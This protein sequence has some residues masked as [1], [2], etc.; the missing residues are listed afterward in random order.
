MKK[1]KKII[2]YLVLLYSFSGIYA[3]G[4]Y[5][6]GANI[7]IGAGVTLYIG[8]TGGNYRNETNVSNG[9]MD[10]SGNLFI[11]GN[12][13]N[14]VAAADIFSSEASG[15]DV[16]FTGTAP[17]TIGGNTSAVFQFPNL[18]MNNASGI[19]LS[20]NA[21]VNGTMTF[22]N[23]LVDIGNN[24]FTFGALSVVAGS[25]SAGTMIIAT[26][27][28]QV[29]KKWAAT[30][31]FTFPVGDNNGTAKYSPLSLNFTDGIFAAGAFVGVNLV[32]AAYPDPYVSGSF[33]KRYWNVTQT[34]ITGFTSN[35]VFQYVP[36]D[37]VG[38]ESII[39]SVRITPTP[40]TSFAPADVT[41]H[42]LIADGLT[43]FGTFTGALGSGNLN[44]KV[45]LE[46]PFN[47]S[48]AMNTTLNTGGLIPLNQP[49]NTAPW[50]Y[51]GTESV[52][53]IPAGI[54]DWIL[55][56]LRDAASPAQAL[57]ATIIPGWP[58]AFFLKSDGSIVN[59]NGTSLANFGN[60]TVTNNLYVV[61]RHR[62]HLAIMSA[63]SPTLTNSVYNYD[64]TT[65]LT[66]AYGGGSGYKQAGSAFA[67][68]TGDI[69]GDGNVY[70]SDFNN[71]ATAF[72]NTG[73]YFKSDLDFDGKAFVSD[74]NKWAIN[75][76]ITVNSGL[77]S[78]QVIPEQQKPKYSSSVPK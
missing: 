11:Q 4:V 72:G 23:G 43:S 42:Q 58:K 27:S 7:V 46:G 31:A 69:D 48:S 71:W 35:A 75:F 3:Q 34:G 62:N 77:K 76:G 37:V 16:A 28:G 8:G 66:Q 22:S 36:S 78:A 1:M 65:G 54:V 44:L 29:Q 67:M 61:I 30:G 25:P 45:F 41:L 53:S 40:I 18:T 49:F 68:V 55:V 2:L 5:N 32:N 10:L 19:V 47:G 57:P 59:L 51:G 70:V 24:N 73:G 12:I 52:A 39:Y 6:N 74:Y 15:S 63:N 9:S 56:E 14:N 38:T 33:L 13:A 20:K 60:S 17:Q 50:N 26:G 21:Q 64:F